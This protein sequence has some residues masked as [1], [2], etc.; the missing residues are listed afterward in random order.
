MSDIALTPK[1]LA[2]LIEK[3]MQDPAHLSLLIQGAPGIG[4]TDI[5]DQGAAAA[6][7]DE[8]TIYC[9]TSDPT[10]PKG[11]PATWFDKETGHQEADF[12]PFG[13]LKRMISATKPLIVFLDDVGGAPPAVQLSFM[14]LLHAR[15]TGDGTP[16]SDHVRFIAATNRRQDRAGVTGMLEPFKSRFTTI[17]ELIPDVDA[18]TQWALTNNLPTELIAFI[19]FRPSMLHDFKPSP[20][21]NNTP[22]PRTVA[23][24]G[25]L[26]QIGLPPEMEYSVFSGAAGEGFAAE[27]LGFLRICRKLPNPDVILM[28]PDKAPVPDDPATLYALCGALS[29]KASDGN[30]ERLVTYSNRLPAEFSVLCMRDVFV[31]KPDLQSTRAAITWFTA[32][33]DV[34]V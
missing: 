31:Q 22:S 6:G 8:L 19:R 5:V 17:V 34:M 30:I 14:N 24:V 11:M 9:A 4:K 3:M 21:L 7:A 13:Y 29:R 10:D 26:M 33:Q 32:H 16:I 15:R 20:D 1:Q 2:I 28:N 25:K 18:W 23:N 12:L 27:F